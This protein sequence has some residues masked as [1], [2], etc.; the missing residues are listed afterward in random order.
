MSPEPVCG[1]PK[2]EAEMGRTVCGACGAKNERSAVVC[3]KCGAAVKRKRKPPL[4]PTRRPGQS[5]GALFVVLD[6]LPGL[7]RLRVVVSAVAVLAA[8]GV[9]AY[10]T[11]TLMPSRLMPATLVTG[12]LGL[13]CCFTALTWL[14][15]GYVVMPTEAVVEFDGRKW[16][17]L[18][19]LTVI[20]VAIV[21]SL[22][23]G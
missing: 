2:G 5:G 23:A 17:V 14:L 7:M 21:A 8:A 18:I 10:L 19:A 13:A 6:L 16:L 15:Y 12:L 3:A 11:V 4:R 20:T 9:L 22:P 1:D